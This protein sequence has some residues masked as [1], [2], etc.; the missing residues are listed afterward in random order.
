MF[1]R[2]DKGVNAPDA[3]KQTQ[4]GQDATEPQEEGLGAQIYQQTQNPAKEAV[5]ETNPIKSVKTNP[6]KDEYTNPFE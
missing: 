3:S 1:M 2:N 6:F 5:P 4:Q